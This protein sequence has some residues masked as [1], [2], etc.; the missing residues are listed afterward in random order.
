MEN[1][2]SLIP[3]SCEDWYE[4]IISSQPDGVGLEEKDRDKFNHAFEAFTSGSYDNAYD[5]FVELAKG[6]SSIS[7]YYLGLMYISGMGVLQDFRQAHMW[8]NIAS[9]RGHKKARKQLDKLTQQ[10][11]ADQLAGAQKLARRR[12]SKINEKCGSSAAD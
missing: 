5:G 1:V 8:L 10:M 6:G 2:L 3:E 12:I 4:A 7:Q 11:T 9:S